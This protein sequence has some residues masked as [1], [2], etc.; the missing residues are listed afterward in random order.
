MPRGAADSTPDGCAY[1]DPGSRSP[2]ELLATPFETVDA[3]E[4][5]LDDEP[6][7]ELSLSPSA[8]SL[9]SLRSVR[10]VPVAVGVASAPAVGVEVGVAGVPVAVGVPG[11]SDGVAVGVP[12]VDVG[13][14][15]PGVEVGVDVPGVEVGVAVPGVPVGVDVGVP[16][17]AVTVGVAVPGVTVKLGGGGGVGGGV[18]P[19]IA[20][21]RATP[22]GMRVGLT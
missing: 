22:T 5:D 10:E 20:M 6:L 4:L 12:G 8:R 18:G 2:G 7:L 17:V 9:L 3:R 1:A 15:V 11:V 16:G 13:V 19:E 21:A 14:G